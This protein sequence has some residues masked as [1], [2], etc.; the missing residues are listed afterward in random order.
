MELQFPLEIEG[1]GIGFSGE[2]RKLYGACC[3][4]FLQICNLAILL[5][6]RYSKGLV[7]NRTELIELLVRKVL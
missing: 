2:K 5:F 1:K 7:L 3:K 6:Y 4:I